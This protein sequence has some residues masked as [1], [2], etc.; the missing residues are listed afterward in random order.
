MTFP[1]RLHQVYYMS[2]LA[3]HGT[4]KAHRTFKNGWKHCR[5]LAQVEVSMGALTQSQ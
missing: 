1:P 5:K 3:Y 2:E 4:H